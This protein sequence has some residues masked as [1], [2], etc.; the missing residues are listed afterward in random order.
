M[1]LK[2]YRLVAFC[3]FAASCLIGVPVA[4]CATG[5][6]IE[7]V[8]LAKRAADQGN[9]YHVSSYDYTEANGSLWRLASTGEVLEQIA[10]PSALAIDFARS[11]KLGLAPINADE[12]FG[13]SDSASNFTLYRWKAQ[14]AF[15]GG[16]ELTLVSQTS[17]KGLVD[18]GATFKDF[19]RSPD[20]SLWFSGDHTVDSV[21][22]SFLLRTNSAGTARLALYD[23]VTQSWIGK[24]APGGLLKLAIDQAQGNLLLGVSDVNKDGLSRYYCYIVSPTDGHLRGRFEI[25]SY[26]NQAD[27]LGADNRLVIVL[28]YTARHFDATAVDLL[29]KVGALGSFDPKGVF[30]LGSAAPDW[31]KYQYQFT[32]DWAGAPGRVFMSESPGIGWVPPTVSGNLVTMPY[33]P[34]AE[35]QQVAKP[36]QKVR[37]V[38]AADQISAPQTIWMPIGG[39]AGQMPFPMTPLTWSKEDDVLKYTVGFDWPAPPIDFNLT[40]PSFFP[41]LGGKSFGVEDFTIGASA[42]VASAGEGVVGMNGGGNLLLGSGKIGLKAAGGAIEELTPEGLAVNGG[43]VSLTLRGEVKEE[44]GLLRLFPPLEAAQS[45]PLIGRILTYLNKKA[46]VVGTVF[47]EGTATASVVKTPK[48]AL[49]LKGENAYAVGLGVTGAIEPVKGVAE[50]AI[51]GEARSTLV[52]QLKPVYETENPSVFTMAF[53]EWAMRLL[54]GTRLVIY[55]TTMAQ[56]QAWTLKY[57]WDE[58]VSPAPAL[59]Q[60]RIKT[61]DLG[62]TGWQYTYGAKPAAAGSL[63]PTLASANPFATLNTAAL[64][65]GLAEHNSQAIVLNNLAGVAAPAAALDPSGRM[66]IVWQQEV[67]GLPATQAT[68]LYYVYYNGTTFTSPKPIYAD[69]RADFHPTVA[70]HKSGKWIVLWEQVGVDNL[71]VTGN[72][73]EDSKNQIAK[74]VPAY[75]LFDPATNAWTVPSRLDSAG[76]CFHMKLATGPTH[77]VTAFWMKSE[78]HQIMPVDLAATGTTGDPTYIYYTRLLQDGSKLAAPKV[79]LDWPYVF[80]DF[81]AADNGTERRLAV[82][83]WNGAVQEQLNTTPVIVRCYENTVSGLGGWFEMD[84]DDPLYGYDFEFAPRVLAMTDG[85]WRVAW[86]NPGSN[87]L[88]LVVT[89]NFDN[90][91]LTARALVSN[92]PYQWSGEY[93]LGES[94]DGHVYAVLKDNIGGNPNLRIVFDDG[95]LASLPGALFDEAADPALQRNLSVAT[96]SNGEIVLVYYKG[97]LQKQSQ[98]LD[99]GGEDSGEFLNVSEASTGQLAVLRHKIVRDLA[100]GDVSL[101]RGVLLE[102]SAAL[103]EA[104]VCNIGDLPV[105]GATISVYARPYASSGLAADD[106][107]TIADKVSLSGGTLLGHASRSVQV[108]WRVPQT[109]AYQAWA[110]VDPAGAIAEA[111]EANNQGSPQL[112]SPVP[113]N[114]AGH[115]AGYR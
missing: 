91:D 110:V 13:L 76:T 14:A 20:G 90:R 80:S 59:A 57:P 103:I 25:P 34:A 112:L 5:D 62:G 63:I 39:Y 93:Q 70:W 105:S 55:G 24:T 28:S 50:A 79:T 18:S 60:A 115:W 47:A 89:S 4:R 54:V 92:M 51:F 6:L 9:A 12:W 83:Q 7:T 65:A 31:V 45:I 36:Y 1:A 99:L 40:M 29:P 77:D 97:A 3:F 44:A 108:S 27:W 52:M 42:E 85:T 16:R 75:S 43:Q 86:Q 107:I 8:T 41:F 106:V 100:A 38:N 95:T 46:K 2:P 17:I 71:A 11:G 104:T 21:T 111:D 81:D 94:A 33:L 30:W 26:D 37:L 113:R 109:A 98:W 114:R 101:A 82:V 102:G 73:L 58:A 53:K 22:S 78:S 48:N 88:S 87:Q 72:A 35:L 74:L 19:A 67:A 66:L 10:V 32:V 68:D 49:A 84:P 56:Q 15:G 69:H 96:A 23:G 64:Q 61:Y